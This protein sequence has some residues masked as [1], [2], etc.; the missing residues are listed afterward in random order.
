MS[1]EGPLSSLSPLAMWTP[2]RRETF[3]FLQEIDFRSLSPR[4]RNIPAVPTELHRLVQIEFRGSPNSME[5][6]PSW[7]TN[8]VSATQEFHRLLWNLKVHHRIHKSP[9]LLGCTEESVQF[10]GLL[11][12]CRNTVMFLRWGV[13]STSPNPQAGWPPFVGCPRLVIQCFCSHPP[14]LEAVPPSATWGRAMLWWRG[15]I[16][17]EV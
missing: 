10:R 15:H 14:H 8:T 12:L 5:Q 1:E 16:R 3:V 9:P 13:V 6:I 2:G 4:A 17:A 11:S 7:E